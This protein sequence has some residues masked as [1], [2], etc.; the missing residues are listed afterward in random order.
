MAYKTFF[1]VWD[2]NPQS[3][4]AFNVAV[5]MTRRAEGHLDVLCVGIDRINPGFYY[6]GTSPELLSESVAAAREEAAQLRREAEEMLDHEDISFAVREAIA[7]FG[8]IGRLIGDRGRYADLIVL[9][10]PYGREEGEA[11]AAAVT[12]AAVFETGAP[13]L[14]VPPGWDGPFARHVIIGWNESPQA[15]RAV[16]LGLPL[17]VEAGEVEVVVVDPPA[18]DESLADPGADLAVFLDRHGANVRVTLLPK[19]RPTVIDTLREH[20]RDVE[21]DLLVMGAY[22]HSRLREAI[23]GGAT[24]EALAEAEI[25]V[26]MAH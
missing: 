20:A 22:G 14:V 1:T 16:R 9:P 24:R 15:M 5:D 25:P 26:L 19:T 12:E 17:L 2:G 7:Q 11:E 18:H 4:A 10:R 6:A 21:G 8:G 23:F 13:V 3:R